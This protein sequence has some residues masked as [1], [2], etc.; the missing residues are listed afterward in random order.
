MTAVGEMEPRSLRHVLRAPNQLT[1]MAAKSKRNRSK[2]QGDRRRRGRQRVS[3]PFHARNYVLMVG[4]LT[5]VVIGY[6]I[7]AAENE[8]DGFLSLYISP[9]LLLAGY[10]GIIYAIIWRPK[11]EE[12]AA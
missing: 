9:I 4:A 10:L 7:M 1:Q 12:G 2:K 8:V 11:E 3:M 5:V 6:A